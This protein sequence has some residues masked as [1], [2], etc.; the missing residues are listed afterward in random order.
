MKLFLDI[1]SNTTI[2]VKLGFLKFKKQTNKKRCYIFT[3]LSGKS[4]PKLCF[5]KF[6]EINDY[7]EESI[8]SNTI[9]R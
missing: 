3:E 8:N 7:V 1:W 2:E 6:T 9:T 4:K 5:T